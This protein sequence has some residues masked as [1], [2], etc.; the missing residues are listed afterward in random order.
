MDSGQNLNQWCN[1]KRALEILGVS[2]STLKN[3]R[4]EGRI[5]SAKVNRVRLYDLGG[6][7]RALSAQ[8][9]NSTSSSES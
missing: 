2:A 5:A 6:F 9:S 1:A 4:Q 7:F 8:A 3:W